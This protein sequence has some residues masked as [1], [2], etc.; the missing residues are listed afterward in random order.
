MRDSSIYENK[1]KN[2]AKNEQY[3]KQEL[4]KPQMQWAGTV[5]VLIGKDTAKSDYVNWEIKKA[6]EMGKRIIGVFLQGAKDE[7]IPSEL[8]EHGHNLVGWN[9]EK[10]VRAINGEDM[11]WENPDGTL[12][13]NNPID[14]PR[15]I[16]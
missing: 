6:A 12:R 8:Y 14:L 10:I 13:D 4:I 15:S 16:C 7:D 2:N 9:G 1:L 11:E 5:V 3:I